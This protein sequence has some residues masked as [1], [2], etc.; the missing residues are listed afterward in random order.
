[1][2][3][4]LMQNNKPIAFFSKQLC[5]RLIRSSTYVRELHAIT[6]TV[7]KWRQYLLGHPFNIHTDHKS[8]KELISQVFQTPEQQVYLSKLLD[9]DFK[10]LYKTGK[11]NVVV[12]ALSRIENENQCLT[13]TMPH[14]V[15]LDDLCTQLNNTPDFTSLLTQIQ[16]NPTNFPDHKIHQGLIFYK[17]KIW[18]NTSNPYKIKLLNEFHNSPISGH[19]SFQKTY[20]RLR[21]NFYWTGMCEDC[22]NFVSQ[23]L[24]CQTTK[25]ETK[26]PA[27]LLQPL[28]LPTAIWEDLSL[29]FITGLPLPM[30]SLSFL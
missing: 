17:N 30:V 7:K 11:T 21:D 20:I 3:A 29:D 8:L 24:P 25:Y 22:K 13:L 14:F 9:F 16:Q 28:P 18:L 4:L 2:G 15:F 27:G 23:C 19:M 10:I 1:M 5:P 6:T 12:D 26:R